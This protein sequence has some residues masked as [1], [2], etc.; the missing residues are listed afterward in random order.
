MFD[1]ADKFFSVLGVLKLSDSGSQFLSSLKMYFSDVGILS[2]I[3]CISLQ[4]FHLCKQGGSVRPLG[5]I[6]PPANA[7]MPVS[8]K[9]W[10]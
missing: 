2:Y 1:Y 10:P 7:A 6:L 9:D 5:A 3:Y 4:L 8:V